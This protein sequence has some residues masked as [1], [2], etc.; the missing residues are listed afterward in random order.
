MWLES[1]LNP[2][3]P[4]LEAIDEYRATEDVVR[5][6]LSEKYIPDPAATVQ[7]EVIY[8]EYVDWSRDYNLH[9]VSM[10]KFSKRLIEDLGVKRNTVNGRRYYKGYKRILEDVTDQYSSWNRWKSKNS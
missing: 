10:V 6:F 5:L 8:N 9:P 3:P 4:V 7:A 2:P 1:G